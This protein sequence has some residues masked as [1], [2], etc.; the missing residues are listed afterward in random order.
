MARARCRQ[1]RFTRAARLLPRDV[2]RRSVASRDRPLLAG[3]CCRACGFGAAR[4]AVGRVDRLTVARAGRCPDV[5]ARGAGRF[6]VT[7]VPAARRSV[8]TRVRA[9][10]AGRRV[11]F[12]VLRRCGDVFLA[13]ARAVVIGLFERLSRR[14]VPWRAD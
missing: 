10:P 5:D 1:L 9:A 2:D 11:V 8:C 7:V 12:A 13:G 3:F 4:V 14:T 6:M